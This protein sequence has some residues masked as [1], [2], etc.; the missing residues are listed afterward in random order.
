MRPGGGRAKGCGFERQVAELLCKWWGIEKSFVRTPGSGAWGK[1]SRFSG[2]SPGADLV[3]PDDF[4][5]S[6]ECKKCE[7]TEL[8]HLLINPEGCAIAGWWKKLVEEDCA[9]T[10]KKPML[11]FSRNHWKIFIVMERED[12]AKS[13]PM[14]ISSRS[15]N[16]F[17]WG[18]CAI[19]LFDDFI[20]LAIKENILHEYG[21]AGGID[22]K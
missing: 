12:L 5:F 4:P 6:I 19:F 15:K 17:L 18:N 16:L 9:K 22:G 11:I 2:A 8:H 3:T 14:F 13:I 10:G 20:K 1:L 7:G 21:K